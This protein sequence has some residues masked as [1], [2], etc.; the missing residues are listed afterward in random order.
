MSKNLTISEA[1]RLLR[2]YA[3]TE[4]DLDKVAGLIYEVNTILA[5]LES[6]IDNLGPKQ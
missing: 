5:V 4:P 1:L 6:R 3:A 2:E